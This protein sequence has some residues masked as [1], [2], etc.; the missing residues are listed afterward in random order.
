MKVWDF[1]MRR[2]PL[3]VAILAIFATSGWLSGAF[4][5][6][7]AIFVPDEASS[8]ITKTET[9]PEITAPQN[10]RTNKLIN[11]KIAK[12]GYNEMVVDNTSSK[13]KKEDNL[14]VPLTS[15]PSNTGVISLWHR[16]VFQTSAVLFVGVVAC[17]LVF[18]AKRCFTLPRH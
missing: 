12:L 4:L 15:V 13:P 1:L 8:L 17:I 2:K 5:R 7:T 10:Y 6:E 14:E 9:K 3:L 11:V 18:L 16:I